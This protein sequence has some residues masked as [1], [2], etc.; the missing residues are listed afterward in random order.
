MIDLFSEFV[1]N[2]ISQADSYF[3]YAQNEYSKLSKSLKEDQ[4]YSS[5]EKKFIQ[6]FLDMVSGGFC[7]A[8]KEVIKDVLYSTLLQYK[9]EKASIREEHSG[10]LLEES[11]ED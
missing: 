8:R 2:L 11:K 1:N 6:R 3:T 5:E 4:S 10:F 9:S 7:Y